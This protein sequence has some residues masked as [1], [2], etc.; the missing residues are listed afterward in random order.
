MLSGHKQEMVCLEYE[1]PIFSISWAR[2]CQIVFS[3]CF[4]LLFLLFLTFSIGDRSELLTGRSNPCC[5]FFVCHGFYH[6]C[7]ISFFLFNNTKYMQ[8][9]Y[10]YIVYILSVLFYIHAASWKCECT[11]LK[12]LIQPGTIMSRA[13]GLA[14]FLHS[15][16]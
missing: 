11:F 1:S 15:K 13:F 10:I 8:C 6:L 12:V 16:V 9:C 5:L 2:C 7:R 14:S 3:F 4:F